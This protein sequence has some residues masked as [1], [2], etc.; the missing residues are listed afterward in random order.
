VTVVQK[1]L[2]YLE[3]EANLGDDGEFTAGD[4]VDGEFAALEP[5]DILT[6]G[7]DELRRMVLEQRAAG[8]AAASAAAPGGGGG[9]G[10]GRAAGGPPDAAAAPPPASAPGGAPAGPAATAATPTAA[11]APA[12]PALAAAAAGAAETPGSSQRKRPADAPAAPPS[13]ASPGSAGRRGPL[14]ARVAAGNGGASGGVAPMDADEPLSPPPPSSAAAAAGPAAPV[15][16]ASGNGGAMPPPAPVSRPGAAGA[17][18]DGGVSL[19]RC[20]TLTGHTSEVFICSW[21]PAG[22][23]GGE[24][25]GGGDGG[26]QRCGPVLLA[27]GSGD[28][29]ARIWEVPPPP[30]GGR[31]PGQLAPVAPPHVL[32]HAPA[33]GSG[34]GNGGGG[35]G[36]GGSGAGSDGGAATAN[37]NNNGARSNGNGKS[38]PTGAQQQ[39]QCDVTTLDW[40]PSGAL[41]ATGSYDGAARV[42][43]PDGALQ[44]TLRGHSGPIFSLRWSRGGRYLLSGGVDKTAVVWDVGARAHGDATAAAAAAAAAAASSAPVQRW[45][46]HRGSTLDVDWRDDSTFAT[47]SSDGTVAVCRVSPRALSA[48]G[49]PGGGGGGGGG[50]LPSSAPLL[51]FAAHADEVNAVRWDPSGRLLASCSDDATAK[52][53]AYDPAEAD[54]RAAAAAAAAEQQQQ[55]GARAAGA[56]GTAAAP[57][58]LARPPLHDLV[59]HG[60]EIYTLRWSPAASAAPLRLATAS[61]DATVRLWDAERGTLLRTLGP[62]GDAVYAL[63]FSPDGRM[64]AT[65]SFDGGVRVWSADDGRLLREHAAGG[66]VFE[67]SWSRDGTMIAAS[68]NAQTVAVCDVRR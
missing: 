55:Q 53:W 1:G 34:G 43:S 68:T 56:N 22:G 51:R 9:G 67:L 54:E 40:H 2:Q 23:A 26:A 24:G 38:S 5:R 47:C 12:A 59:G 39:Q 66:G 25:E 19:T 48:Q 45:A 61:F 16:P 58:P 7:V 18:A 57:P 49:R 10:K 33:G 65:G 27:S 14:K 4:G 28:G 63:A 46:H 35:G 52:V 3:L 17:K 36:G 11:P 60:K 6:K 62:H 29:T 13:A 32:R 37:A 64:V 8:A 30:P 15:A 31:A 44:R 41:L 42:W 21:S 50:P 20:A